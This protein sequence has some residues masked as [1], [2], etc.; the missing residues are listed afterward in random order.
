MILE[1]VCVGPMQVNC[2]ILALREDSPA[3]IIDPGGQAR[4]IRQ[5]LDKHK[6][7]PAF[8]INTHGHYDHIGS[9]DEFGVPVYVHNKD[10]ALLKD[11]RLNLSGLFAL[12]CRVNAEIKILEDGQNIGL[13]GLQLEVLHVPG[14][15]AGGIALR[16]IKPGAKIVFTGDSLFCRSI[17]RSDLDGGDEALLIKTIKEKLLTL[18]DD[19]LIYPGHGPSSTIGEEKKSNPFLT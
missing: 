16:M 12:P 17:G 11:P 2:Y 14:H 8:I 5:A 1:T 15:T 7:K 4:K 6:L 10:L 13:E 9:D 3:I 18:S 19:T